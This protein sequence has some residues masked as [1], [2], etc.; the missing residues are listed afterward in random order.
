MSL[1]AT[2]Q[3][4]KTI[5][6]LKTDAKPI[7]DQ[8]LYVSEPGKEGHFYYDKADVGTPENTGLVLV[9]GTNRYKRKLDSDL[10]VKKSW[11]TGTADYFDNVADINA[12]ITSNYRIRGMRFKVF[13]EGIMREYWYK[14]GTSDNDI[15]QINATVDT[16]GFL[17]DSLSNTWDFKT[18]NHKKIVLNNNASS[19]ITLV[20]VPNN[21]E[22]ILHFIQGTGGNKVLTLP[23]LVPTGLSFSTQEGERDVLRF[24]KDGDGQIV[25]T[26]TNYGAISGGGVNPNPG[27]SVPLGFTEIPYTDDDIIS[28]FRGPYS[29]HNSSDR[30]NYPN[31]G[32]TPAPMDEYRRTGIEW[33]R[34]EPTQGNY[35]F[36][37]VLGPLINACITGTPRR[38]IT[39]NVMAIYAGAPGSPV[40]VSPYAYP[41]YLHNLMQSEGVKDYRSPSGYWIPNYNSNNFL[42]R[43]EALLNAM[44]T[45][46][47][48]TSYNGVLYADVIG[49][50]D[51]GIVGEYGEW[52]HGSTIISTI[53]AG[54]FGTSTSFN[55]II[56]AHIN[57]FPNVPLNANMHT[58]DARY[59]NN[60]WIPPETAYFALNASNNWGKLGIAR[61]NYG[62]ANVDQYIND[63]LINNN[64]GINGM[65]FG[66]EISERWKYAPM[67]GEGPNY[68]T[69]SGCGGVP[70]CNLMNEVLVY[71]TSGMGNGNYS[72]TPAN[73]STIPAARANLRA[74]FKRMGYRVILEGGAM[75]QTLIPGQPF[76]IS[77]NW[78]NVG[79]APVYE[80]WNVQFLLKSGSTV[81]WT[82][83]S[84]HILKLWL[85]QTTAT[86][87]TDSFTLPS[88]ISSGTYTMSIRIT[89]PK[90]Y[91]D[92][93]PL[94]IQGRQIDGS[95]LLRTTVNVGSGG[96][97]STPT[98]ELIL[99]FGESGAAG[100]ALDTDATALELSSRSIVKIWNN[101]TNVF[102]N[103]DVG[104]NNNIN[105][106][107]LAGEHG[108][109]LGLANEVAA[110]R[111]N[112]PVYL[113]KAAYSGSLIA[114]HLNGASVSGYGWAVMKARMDGAI[115]YLNSNSIPFK[116]TVWT[117]IG[118]NDYNV[119][120]TATDYRN[121]VEQ[122]RS[123]FRGLYGNS[124][125]MH[126]EHLTNV[127][128]PF[129]AV[130]DLIAQND[131]QGLSQSIPGDD[132]PMRDLAHRNY[133]GMKIMATK[134]V[135]A[136][137]GAGIPT[138]TSNLVV[139]LGDDSAN[140][141][142]NSAA[143]A[144]EIASRSE[145]RIINNTSLGYEDLA[146]G[147][148][149]QIEQSI[150]TS[151][152]GLELGLANEALAG[153]LT[154]PT[155]FVK[156]TY[157]YSS[158]AEWLNGGTP[159]SV[160]YGWSKLT[161]R[162]N[163][164]RTIL[165][166]T[167]TPY[168]ITV[169][170][171]IGPKDYNTSVPGATYQ[172]NLTQLRSDFRAL[173]GASVKFIILRLPGSHPYNTNI[174]AFANADS[175]TNVI[176]T[177]AFTI[178][179]G[180]ND[181]A[182]FSY[183]GLKTISASIAALI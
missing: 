144:P 161:A 179:S 148:N 26:I 159:T 108:W 109:E 125:P 115:A 15:I 3:V 73:A 151:E 172:A 45:Y 19:I 132:A 60:T 149:N 173:Y 117:S 119:S 50:M 107:V 150:P 180:L 123:D 42:T 97:G 13:E 71:H 55:R 83:T 35:A 141:G 130:I 101:N 111:L 113:V 154:N 24:I 41:T 85:P 160:D 52:H 89:D 67:F 153:N 176:D 6:K 84:S 23:G 5:A 4:F 11:F 88:N 53:P 158:T 12:I 140:R 102:E 103:L 92:P 135:S 116:I 17:S 79:I 28:P 133:A 93:F 134:F 10:S 29:W 80:N 126:M 39:F 75:T 104:T 177:S 72:D 38:R 170:M 56:Q 129:N 62:R 63:T 46:F 8:L 21:T 36:S 169:V 47:N 61:M 91:R 139:F 178:G 82:G 162:V 54:V 78:K 114:E 64:R 66:Y 32:T 70:F 167:S 74:A 58:F 142:L 22:G 48:T 138:T 146:I 86:I 99:I 175:N 152:H 100:R 122:W 69:S 18:G 68:D 105:Q 166:N 1:F 34:L 120:T 131:P 51:I 77:L 94:A 155:Y 49:G 57:A 95:Y 9:S 65:N 143:T 174:T 156:S 25:W 127:Y 59:L 96:G 171:V 145:L 87:V 121:R 40:D 43:V 124:I 44:A 98:A 27:V 183:S 20:N 14:D 118:I 81:V 16:Q 76:Q 106:N 163:A 137:I 2:T 128:H 110:G 37:T 164:A 136:T 90:N 30:I 33:F 181:A 182:H 112:S 157:S 165:G 31:D 168:V 7:V 147:T